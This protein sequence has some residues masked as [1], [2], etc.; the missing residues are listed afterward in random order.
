MYFRDSPFLLNLPSWFQISLPRLTQN[1]WIPKTQSP[2]AKEIAITL[3]PQKNSRQNSE[4]KVLLG[5]FISWKAIFG[6]VTVI[7]ILTI[8]SIICFDKFWKRSNE[9]RLS[10]AYD[11][12]MASK[13]DLIIKFRGVSSYIKFSIRI[14]GIMILVPICA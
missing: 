5:F 11:R 2:P 1:P 3:Q 10:H 8:T 12:V 14:L 9:N 4:Q 7:T 13:V 6:V